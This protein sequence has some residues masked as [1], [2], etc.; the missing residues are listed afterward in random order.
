MKSALSGIAPHIGTLLRERWR[1]ALARLDAMPPRERLALGAMALAALLALELMVVLPIRERRAVLV[2]AM[3][4][5][6]QAVQDNATAEQTR[7]LA[8]QAALEAQ[9]AAAELELR[10][11]G[12]GAHRSEALGHWLHKAL[13]GQPVQV[14][15]L[16][17]LGAAELEVAAASAGQGTS[18]SEA[19]ADP[20]GAGHG[21]PA[22]AA[23]QNAPLFRHRYELMLAGDAEPLITAVRS[24]GE[25]M[26]PLRIERVRLGSRDGRSV[27][28]T[29]G[30]VIIS[31]ERSWITL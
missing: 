6:A 18:P 23:N 27:E 28:A 22:S 8:E 2:G 3:A 4:A 7:L 14:V 31:P 21:G 24:L 17:S 15:S 9:L 19:A 29:L 10:K 12:A 1:H 25:R 30:F 26:R 16:R 11:R 13:A 5:E 20:A